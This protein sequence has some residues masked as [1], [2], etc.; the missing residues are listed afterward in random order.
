MSTPLNE[1]VK[2]I[3]AEIAVM[4]KIDQDMRRSAAWDAQVDV[5][6][7]ERIKIFLQKYGWLDRSLVGEEAAHNLWLL[8][9]HA[10]HDSAFQEMALQKLSAAVARG[11]ADKQDEAY[12]TDRVRVNANRPQVYGT[13]FY[14]NEHGVF[15]PRPV[16]NL[17]QLD[18]RRTTVGLEPFAEYKRRLEQRQRNLG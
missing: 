15:G 16:E 12:L 8:V 17:D 7:T 2:K 10:D 4:V 3:V 11:E 1:D 14:S 18:E 5:R 13:Q 6:H 9:Q